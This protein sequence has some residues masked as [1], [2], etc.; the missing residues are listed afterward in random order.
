MAFGRAL[1]FVWR[2]HWT[3]DPKKSL[4]LAALWV[5]AAALLAWVATPFP[6]LQITVGVVAGVLVGTLQRRSL[7]EAPAL[8]REAVTSVQVRR[9]AA[10]TRAGRRALGL[11]WVAAFALLGVSFLALRGGPAPHRSPGYGLLCGYFLLMAL[12]DLLVVPGLQKLAAG[13]G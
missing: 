3:L 12:R 11:Q 1:C 10:S 5:A 4:A 13:R 6:L 2:V 8:Y 9:A 7:D